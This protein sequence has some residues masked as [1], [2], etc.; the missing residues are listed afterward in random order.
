MAKDSLEVE[1][2]YDVDAVVDVPALAGV[3]AGTVDEA[4]Y[5]EELSA[6]YLDTADLRLRGARITLRHRTGGGD[7]GWHLKLPAERGRLEV[8]SSA[9]G[10]PAEVPE[11][12]AALVRA[13]VRREQ[14]TPVAQL[15]T[16]RTVHPLH[17]ADGR[18]LLELVDD[19][20]EGVPDGGEVL[21]WREW[22]AE[23][24]AGE[25]GLLDAVE[26]RL[27]GAGA[28][29][30][31]SASKVG[32][33][34]ESRPGGVPATPSRSVGRKATAGELV[35]AHLRAQVAEV[36]ARDPQ[37][38]RDAADSVH[39]MRVATRR[40]RSAL[41]TFRPLLDREVTDPLRDEL[42]WLA[43]ELGAARDAEVMHERLLSLLAEQPA[44]LVL[45]PVRRKVDD[46]LGGRY[47]D[48][49]KQV[50]R[51]LDG[52]RYLDLLDALDALVSDPP[53]APQ[54]ARPAAKVIPKLVARA[55]R[56]LVRALQHAEHATGAE[57][58][59]ALHEARKLAKRLRYACEAV[60]PTLPRA[61]GLG[62][63]A[64][65]LQEVLGEHQDSVVLREALREFGAASSRS[66]ENGFT[67]GRLHGLEQAR[68]DA[69]GEQWRRA[70]KDLSKPKLR[71]WL[72]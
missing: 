55:D 31:P 47:R 19:R 3:A 42:R 39:K 33:V 59:E 71:R 29:P 40:L 58:D 26:Q 67:F 53:F 64:T 13:V 24:V 54:A 21:R 41:R 28:V 63:A 57:Q 14:L 69:R 72:E 30:S 60:A 20:V 4:P 38:R 52:D 45:G 44:E 32:R 27:V 9:D 18:I 8:H 12:L 62:A 23:L 10:P 43:G 61:Q 6:T 50:L 15:R 5:V 36:V 70:W 46:V 51:E 48:A 16:T 1:R 66:G 34:L 35:Q 68:A 56:H 11:D 37:V 22:E 7:A 25:D 49:H 65:S 17:D 2:K